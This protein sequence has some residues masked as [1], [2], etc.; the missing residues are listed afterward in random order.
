M[1]ITKVGQFAKTG[2]EGENRG[3]EDAVKAYNALHAGGWSAEAKAKTT[4]MVNK[5]YDL[6]TSFYEFGWG[7]SFHFAHRLKARALPAAC[8]GRPLAALPRLR[9]A[10]TLLAPSLA[11]TFR[12]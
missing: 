10:P 9:P 1:S 3:V 12:R 7:E 4:D 2:G 6:A 11:P 8:L 5:Y